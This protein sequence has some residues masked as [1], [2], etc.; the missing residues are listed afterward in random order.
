MQNEGAKNFIMQRVTDNGH[1]LQF[2]IVGF[3][4]GKILCS[5]SRDI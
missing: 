5:V 2:R 3:V 1:I 4:R